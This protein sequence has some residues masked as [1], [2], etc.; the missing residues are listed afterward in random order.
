MCAQVLLVTTITA[1]RYGRVC[2]ACYASYRGWNVLIHAEEVL[3]IKLC[4][5][6][7]QARIVGPVGGAH[8]LRVFPCTEGVHVHSAT[9]PGGDCLPTIPRPLHMQRV[10]CGL[11]PL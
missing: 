10:V 9:G 11:A 7:R 2:A 5:Q 4:F 3:G 1:N 6:C 8:R